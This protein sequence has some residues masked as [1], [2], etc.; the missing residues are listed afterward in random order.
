MT[1]VVAVIFGVFAIGLIVLVIYRST[2]TMHKDEQL[3]LDDA[4]SLMHAEQTEL[5]TKVNRLT[6][7]VRVFGMGSGLF[8]LALVAMWIYQKLN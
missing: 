8:F 7:P 5:L 2:L 1:I 6:L 4:S 3:F